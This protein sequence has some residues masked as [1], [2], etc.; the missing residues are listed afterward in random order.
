MTLD[1]GLFE[2]H[3]ELLTLVVATAAGIFALWRWMVDQ[4]WRRVQYAQSLIKEFVEKKGTKKTFEI[5]DTVGEDDFDVADNSKRK[6]TINITDDFLIGALSTFDQKEENDEDELI[7]RS[8]LDDFF[9]ELAGFQSHIEAGLIK[10]QD[11]KPYL[12]YWFAELTGSGRVRKRNFARQ[13]ARYL[14]YFGYER[15]LTLVKNMGYTFPAA[16]SDAVAPVKPSRN[17]KPKH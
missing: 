13:V 2:R 16:P 10:Q 14:S 11:I 17:K 4:K 6:R 5:L 8:I 7:V 1:F 15:V 3:K 9:G 12:E